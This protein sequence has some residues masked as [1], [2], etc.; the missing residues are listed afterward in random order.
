MDVTVEQPLTLT[1]R[2]VMQV[3]FASMTTPTPL[4]ESRLPS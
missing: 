4:G 2:S 1:P 3:C